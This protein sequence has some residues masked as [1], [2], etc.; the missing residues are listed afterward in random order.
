MKSFFA[1]IAAL[2]L[3][4]AAHGQ[5]VTASAQT[6]RPDLISKALNMCPALL[7]RTEEAAENGH[8]Q[9]YDYSDCECLANSI[10]YNTWDEASAGY[11]GPAMPDSDAY[12]IVGAIA[13]SDTIEEATTVIDA[14]VSETGYSAVSACYEK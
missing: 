10:D 8:M 11:Y 9:F 7:T 6:P 14:N 3:S 12:I 2:T 1:V 13:A 5:V 4:V